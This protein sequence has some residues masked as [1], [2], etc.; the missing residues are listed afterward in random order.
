[1]NLPN[2]YLHQPVLLAPMAGY[3]D[4]CFRQLCRE[5]G[6]DLTV[7]E[8][9]S[10]KGLCFGN[11][12]TCALLETYPGEHPIAAQLF[13]SDPGAMAR[14]A[15]YL[16]D[17]MPGRFDMIDLNMG[18]PAPKITGNGDGSALMRDPAL[19]ARIVSA[20][21][22]ASPLPVTVKLRRGFDPAHENAVEFARA[23]ADAGAAA[24]TVHGR[25]RT[26]MYAGRADWESIA[27][28]KAAV[29]I[30]VIGNGDVDSGTAARAMLRETGADGVMVGRAALGNPFLFAEIRAA[31]SGKPYTPPPE[32]ER[33]SM[34]RR[35][36]RMLAEKKGERAVIE[37]RKHLIFYVRSMPGAARLRTEINA[38]GSLAALLEILA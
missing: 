21:V 25:T 7:T 27:R 32:A 9:V 38:C 26:Q 16:A 17:E 18:C 33:L 29:S 12:K 36:A 34:A 2:C 35:H 28:V 23:L 14:A 1:M 8:M 15:R 30:P 13:G 31:L 11:G 19:A 20:C 37:L 4:A 24:L 3:T 5:Q 10:A 22:S 6:A